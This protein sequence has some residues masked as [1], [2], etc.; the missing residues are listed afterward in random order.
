MCSDTCHVDCKIADALLKKGTNQHVDG[1]DT[2]S[3]VWTHIVLHL[4]HVEGGYG[5][6][7]NDVTKDTAFYTTTSR[8]VTCLGILPG[9]SVVV[10]TKGRSSGLILMVIAPLLLLRDIH[11]KL[12]TQ[13]DCKE[14][15]VTSQSQINVG[16]SARLSSQDDVSQYQGAAPLL[17][18]QFNL[19]FEISSV[20]DESSVSNADVTVIPSHQKVTQQILSH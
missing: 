18:P 14:V 11:V 3:K 17:L 16:T 8:F 2:S 13:Y 15:C 6:T 9:T 10:V 7:F 19:L 12:I 5:I 20:R 1:W 4:L